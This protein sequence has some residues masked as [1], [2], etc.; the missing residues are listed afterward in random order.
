MGVCVKLPFRQFKTISLVVVLFLAAPTLAYAGDATS[1]RGY[2]HSLDEYVIYME[3]HIQ[4][5]VIIGMDIQKR[6]TEFGDVDPKI[7]EQYLSL[8]DQSKIKGWEK[9]GSLARRLYHFYGRVPTLSPEEIPAYKK[10]VADLN[11]SDDRV[12]GEFLAKLPSAI[13]IKLKR[14]EKIADQIDRVMSPVSPEEWGR[15][16]SPASLDLTWMPDP[17][18]RKIALYYERPVLDKDGNL[19]RT[20][21]GRPILNRSFYNSLVAPAEYR[22][23]LALLKEDQCI[24]RAITAH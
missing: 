9:Q 12:S 19:I 16:M 11:E 18:D 15:F 8:H 14:I 21:S 10:S 5:Q 3:S 6:F 2:V 24:E 1:Q 20:K 13:A 22:H 23:Y 7:L 4:R 17:K